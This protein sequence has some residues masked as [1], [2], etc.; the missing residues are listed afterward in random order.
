MIKK[1]VLFCIVS[2]STYQSIEANYVVETDSIS[3]KPLSTISDKNTRSFELLDD[4]LG[5]PLPYQPTTSEFTESYIKQHYSPDSIT[6]D[7]IDEAKTVIQKL[8]A[9][10]NYVDLIVSNDLVTLPIG[11]T[12]KIGTITYTM[13]ISKA[14]IMPIILR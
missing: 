7:K 13:A 6:G 5:S 11:V 3:K 14:K 4:T 2:I 9:S 8:I 12:K 10:Q 1:F